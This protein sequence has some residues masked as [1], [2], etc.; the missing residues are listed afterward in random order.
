MQTV[1]RQPAGGR[2]DRQSSV[3][4]SPIE[5]NSIDKSSVNQSSVHL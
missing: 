4:Q 5:E 3:D 2:G 1:R